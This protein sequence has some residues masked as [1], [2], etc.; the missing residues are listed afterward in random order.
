MNE[1]SERKKHNLINGLVSTRQQILDLYRALPREIQNQ[2]FLGVWSPSDLVAHLIGWDYTN[3]QA[4]L[5]ILA[6]TLPA[7]YT[8][9]DRDWK[10][11]NSQLVACHK[12]DDSTS[13]MNAAEDSH[14]KLIALIEE[15]SCQQIEHD[16]GVRV[17]RYKVTI[18][19]LLEAELSDEGEHFEQ[20]KAFQKLSKTTLI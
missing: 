6:G 16:Y 3:A 10:T 15:L 2:V 20:L 8:H 9:R 11:Y 7:F 17:G 13:L 1:D 14:R 4:I 5:E 12:V 19:R 18:A